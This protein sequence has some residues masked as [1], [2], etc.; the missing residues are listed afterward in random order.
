[1]LFVCCV[2]VTT[3][4]VLCRMLVNALRGYCLCSRVVVWVAICVLFVYLVVLVHVCLLCFVSNCELWCVYCSMF[5]NV[6]SMCLLCVFV[7]C[8]LMMCVMSLCGCV[9][10]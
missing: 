2:Q 1:M 4:M 7:L 5:M 8:C 9:C 10:C 6:C 3:T